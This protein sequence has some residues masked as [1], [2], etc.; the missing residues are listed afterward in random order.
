MYLKKFTMLIGALLVGCS[1]TGMLQPV[2]PEVPHSIL[3][4]NVDIPVPLYS[5][6]F[7]LTDAQQAE[8]MAYFNSEERMHIPAHMRLY[9][10]LAADFSR[11]NYMGKNYTA[12]EAYANK[13][14]N[15]MSLAVLTKALADHAGIK[16]EFQSIVSAP[17]YNMDNSYMLASDHVRSFLYDPDFIEKSGVTYFVKPHV[18]I[19]YFPSS[20]DIPG[21]RISENTFIAM[22][23][24]NL[25]ADAL[26]EEQYEYALALLRTALEYD[27]TYGAVINLV[28]VLHR[29]LQQPDLAEM[30]YLYGLDVS[31]T[32]A[33]LL[34]NYAVLQYENGNP[35][36]AEELLQSLKQQNDKDPYLWLT[37]GKIALHKKQFNEAILHLS[38]AV[39]QAP[40]LPQL[41]FE[42]AVAYYLN[43]NFTDARYSLE[44]AA[45][46]AGSGTQKQH[47]H[48]KLNA[49]NARH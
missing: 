13:S 37:F 48:A 16:I 41:H 44:K 7:T 47:Y 26:L 20:G 30:F 34:S 11:F 36:I 32:K 46:L 6:I 10:F 9:Q 45:E 17:V 19:D 43:Q 4:S 27:A 24:R 38:K 49:I 22:F 35:E 14:G 29:R 39:T 1:Q 15:C 8:F 2:L 31:T 42:L 18:V 40:Y 5:E 3:L 12:S 23:Y 21:P 33:S 25:A 28:A